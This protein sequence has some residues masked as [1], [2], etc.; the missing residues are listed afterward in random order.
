MLAVGE[1]STTANNTG[2]CNPFKRFELAPLEAGRL[3]DFVATM[4]FDRLI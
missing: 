3:H 1:R 4:T 2:V